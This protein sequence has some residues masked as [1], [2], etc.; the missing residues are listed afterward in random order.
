MM[1]QDSVQVTPDGA[2][3]LLQDELDRAAQ[4]LHVAGLDAAL[5]SYV[6]A[7][8]IALQLGPA[9]TERVLHVVLGTGRDLAQQGDASGLSA[10][11]PALVG[12]VARVREAGVLPATPIMEA[13]AA[14]VADVGALVGQVGLALT[15]PPQDRAGLWDTA[16]A[17][18][19][20][21]DD[22]TGH[23]FALS[24]WL[25]DVRPRPPQTGNKPT[26]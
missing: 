20:L 6:G 14:V 11:G 9:A 13:W 24:A 18:A 23:L 2:V 4:A 21:L 19:G 16:C 1:A 3:S 7:L 8:G 17:R 25:A 22:A 10:L 15:I 5:G 26:A 12:L